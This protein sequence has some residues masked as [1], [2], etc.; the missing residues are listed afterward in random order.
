MKKITTICNEPKTKKKKGLCRTAA[1]C[2]VST[3]L[4]EQNDSFEVQCEYYKKLIEDDPNR[5][6]VGIYGDQT[7]G[8]I[9]NKRAEF[10]RMIDDCNNGKIDFIITRSVS[11]FSRNMGDCLNTINF[12]KQK[13]IGILFE[14]ENIC[15]T[16]P[17]SELFLSILAL[18]AQEESNHISLN[19][20]W[21]ALHRDELGIPNRRC[22]YGYRKK[23]DEHGHITR[24]WEICETKAKKVKIMFDMAYHLSTFLEIVKALNDLEL[25]EKSGYVWRYPTIYKMLQN[26]A[27]KGDLLTH[28]TYIKDFLTKKQ[29][30][31]NGE[32]EQVYLE[33][34]HEAIV[35][36]KI[37]DRV[38]V[39]IKKRLLIKNNTENRRNFFA[40]E[41]KSNDTDQ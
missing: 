3:L 1:Y 5:E 2:R 28:K 7:S 27:Y 8:L 20:K 23:K 15:S 31:N 34:H 13:G 39:Y 6:L 10:L 18:M 26:E 25:K 16:D 14:K 38:N 29:I 40:K 17:N 21:A 11:R 37:F 4:E 41:I 24:E 22:P 33:D 35:S 36:R 9:T 32:Y 12:L 30:P 19:M